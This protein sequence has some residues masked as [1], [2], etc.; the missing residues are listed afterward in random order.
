MPLPSP[1][2]FQCRKCQWS[3]TVRPRS[4]V[5]IGVEHIEACPQCGNKDLE[6]APARAEGVLG[7]VAA[8]VKFW[9]G[10]GR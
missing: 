1:T 3:K 10:T 9:K 2:T 4:D 8:A 6:A 5:L 7:A